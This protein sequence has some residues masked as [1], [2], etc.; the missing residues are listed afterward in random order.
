MILGTI[1]RWINVEVK[2]G[3]RLNLLYIHI[4][5][6]VEI[7]TLISN[8]LTYILIYRCIKYDEQSLQL[9]QSNQL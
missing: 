7:L 9:N 3:Y 1:L 6:Y 4:Y 8:I 5:V 2:E